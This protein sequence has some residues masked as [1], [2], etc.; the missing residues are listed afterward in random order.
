MSDINLGDKVV[1]TVTGLKGTAITKIEFLNGCIQ[2]QVQPKGITSEGKIMESEYIDQQ[3]LELVS[4]PK[5][6]K[7]KSNTGGG[8][9]SYP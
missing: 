2:F 4:K 7:E 8:F 1:D 5:V 9:R 6:K 3:Q